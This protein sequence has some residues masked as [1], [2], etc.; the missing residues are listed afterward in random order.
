MNWKTLRATARQLFHRYSHRASR[1]TLDLLHRAA[2]RVAGCHGLSSL[3]T[4]SSARVLAS[5]ITLRDGDDLSDPTQSNLQA[6]LRPRLKKWS[7]TVT[8]CQ[9]LMKTAPKNPI[10]FPSAPPECSSD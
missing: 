3:D 7:W 2:A 6:H 4:G 9:W 1:G 5:G 10:L 8:H